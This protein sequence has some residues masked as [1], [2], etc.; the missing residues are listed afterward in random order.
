MGSQGNQ[1]ERARGM[2]FVE[3]KAQDAEHAF[4]RG[5]ANV[6]VWWVRWAVVL[7]VYY[8]FWWFALRPGI[9]SFDSGYY[10]QE[11]LSGQLTNHKPFLFARFLQITSLGGA[12]PELSVIVQATLV[13]LAFSRAFALGMA[14]RAPWWAIT[15]CLLLVLNPYTVFMAFYLQNDVLYCVA[16]LAIL[17]ETLNAIRLRRV[18]NVSCIIIA[19]A[20]P[21]A[22]GFR[23]NGLL[24]LPLWW[25]LF[26]FLLPPAVF[27]RPLIAS[28]GISVLAYASIMGVNREDRHDVFYP[29]VIHESIRLAQP[30]FGHQDGGSL[31]AETRQVIGPELVSRA[32]PFYWPL[33]WDTIAFFPQ[34]P[35]L[36][37]LPEAQRAAVV[38]SF[39]IHDLGPSLSSIVGHRV[40]LFLGAALARAEYVDPYGAPSNIP[41]SVLEKKQAVG[42]RMRDAGLSG[43]LAAI[44]VNTRAWTW[45]ALFG[46][47]IL[48][49]LSA[50]AI[51]RRHL[52]WLLVFGLLWIQAA[53]VLMLA[54]SAEYRYVF[55]LY[56]APL[57]LL[58][59]VPR[60]CSSGI[61]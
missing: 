43:H 61:D 53:A 23:E 35:Q 31:S 41:V 52:R 26:A 60:A 25:C 58:A 27:R 4:A 42:A 1:A 3:A 57:M 30:V 51:W 7:S 9:F 15:V 8:I 17:M 20:S 19:I 18:G 56:L 44:S 48:A 6:R 54:P 14:A 40:E 34:G 36:A 50:M 11:V 29:A 47:G 13:V 22:L 28:V 38:H 32:L 5:D 2:T 59:Y 46:V 12:L 16:I 39:L 24:F 33:Y 55:M 45:N 21:M 49:L 37:T 10:L